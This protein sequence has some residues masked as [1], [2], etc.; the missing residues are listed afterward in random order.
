MRSVSPRSWVAFILLGAVVPAASAEA[1]WN[2]R[3]NAPQLSRP[4][5]LLGRLG[6][7]IT[8]DEEGQNLVAA[9]ETFSGSCGPA[10]KTPCPPPATPGL[11]GIG[12]STD[13]GRTWVDIGS[14]LPVDGAFTSGHAWLDRGGADRATYFLVSRARSVA[15]NQLI[16]T[17]VYRGRFDHGAFTWLGGHLFVPDQPGDQQ[18]S[19]SILA[20]K[21]GSGLVFVA[22]SNLRGLCGYPGHGAGQIEVVR[23]PDSGVTWEKRIVV[24]VDD[25]TVTAD[26]KDPTCGSRGTLQ[27]I[28]SMAMGPQGEV[29]VSWSHGPVFTNYTPSLGATPGI[30]DLTCT[31]TQ[32]VAR[33]LDGG[34]TFGPPRDVAEANSMRQNPPVGYYRD[35]VNDFPRIAVA[36]DG[37]HRGRIYVSYTSAVTE[38][39][40]PVDVQVLTSSQIFLVYS[41]DR[42]ESWSRPVPLAPPVPPT[43]VKR[44]WPSV[45][46]E[47]GGRVDVVYSESQERPAGE[48][49]RM[50]LMSGRFRAGKA[51]SLVDLYRVQS[52]DGGAHFGPPVRLTTET[53]NWCA[54]QFDPLNFLFSNFGDYLGVFAVRNRTFAV[55]TDGRSGVPE[56]YFGEVASP[57]AGAA[58]KGR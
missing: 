34:K 42:G 14:P 35:E 33:S 3:M 31:L 30:Y 10:W 17:L 58:P 12:Y 48:D 24:G 41:D 26:P 5:G 23:S 53:T 4:H 37:P 46:V 43:G 45:A 21:D 49:C 28:P 8:G 44:L 11:T 52:Q 51:S 54:T 39:T 15:T 27:V 20:A 47:P 32:R 9:W 1:P 18:R 40:A 16:G 36:Q 19:Q 55:W 29:Y 7:A 22:I 25:T 2:V 50:V 6:V 38:V 13:G 56:A 57:G